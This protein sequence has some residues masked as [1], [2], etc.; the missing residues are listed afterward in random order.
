MARFS[1]TL[2]VLSG[3]CFVIMITSLPWF[4]VSLT[5]GGV[6]NFGSVQSIPTHGVCLGLEICLLAVFLELVVWCP[7]GLLLL[8]L[9]W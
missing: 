7:W 3:E 8:S 9:K 5:P 1:F 2:F 6:L 4:R